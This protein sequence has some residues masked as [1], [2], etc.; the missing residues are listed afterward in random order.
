MLCNNFPNFIQEAFANGV[1]KAK[2]LQALLNG[3][4][5]LNRVQPHCLGLLV[6]VVPTW[7]TSTPQ[8]NHS[9]IIRYCTVPTWSTSTLQ[10]NHSG[11]IR[12]CT[13]R[14]YSVLTDVTCLKVIHNIQNKAISK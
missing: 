8:L 6:R 14:K 13:V 3:M 10:L 11:I 1:S 9:G 4:S 2:L 5:L 12:Y 7:S